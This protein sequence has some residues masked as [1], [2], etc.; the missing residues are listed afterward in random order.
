MRVTISLIACATVLVGT[1]AHADRE[2]G[3]D[4]FRTHCV[5]CHAI[6][7][8]RQGPMLRGVMGRKAAS[9]PDFSGYSAA[10]KASDILWTEETLTEFLTDPKGFVPGTGMS[11]VGKLDTDADRR[12]L[13]E[14]LRDPDT[15]LDLCF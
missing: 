9:V 1:S 15:S 12:D 14:F 13:I 8:N 6:D 11:V 10:M 7:C 5:G 4:L 2:R 3:R